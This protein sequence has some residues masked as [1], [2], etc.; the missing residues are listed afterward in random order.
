VGLVG[1]QEA[2]KAETTRYCERHAF[3]TWE[4]VRP[5]KERRNFAFCQT[6]LRC[7]EPNLCSSKFHLMDLAVDVTGPLGGH[8]WTAWTDF[9][10][11]HLVHYLSPRTIFNLSC[12]SRSL[13]LLA[14][15][16]LIP[17]CGLAFNEFT[18]PERI[19]K[20]LQKNPSMSSVSLHWANYG[21]LTKLGGLK[22]LS[23]FF[24]DVDGEG[25][26]KERAYPTQ[27]LC[28]ISHL[29][30]LEALSLWYQKDTR[31]QEG[32]LMYEFIPPEFA[33]TLKC[34]KKLKKLALTAESGEIPEALGTMTQLE[35]L[36]VVLGGHTD[37]ESRC[38]WDYF[39]HLP[40]IIDLEMYCMGPEYYK[41][42]LTLTKLTSLK[43]TEG[44]IP[45]N[46]NIFTNLETLIV[47]NEVWDEIELPETATSFKTLTKLKKLSLSSD[48]HHKTD[49]SVLLTLT[50]LA[51]TTKLFQDTFEDL[52][53]N[54][55][56]AFNHLT[57][58]TLEGPLFKKT[59]CDALGTLTNLEQLVMQFDC[60]DLLYCLSS[61]T[62]LISLKAWVVPEKPIA[63][64]SD[65]KP[66]NRP[67]LKYLSRLTNL[68]HLDI[69]FHEIPPEN[70]TCFQ[71][72]NVLTNLNSLYLLNGGESPLQWFTHLADL[73]VLGVHP[74][75]QDEVSL[76]TKYFP[77]IQKLDT[78][79]RFPSL[80]EPYKYSRWIKHPEVGA[81]PAVLVPLWKL[82][83]LQIV[84]PKTN[85]NE[86]KKCA[87]MWV[88][89]SFYE[90]EKY[91]TQ[92]VR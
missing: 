19:S 37:D 52:F 41:F 60:S 5:M 44:T 17:I 86:T 83:N 67:N 57:S 2:I 35:T 49:P 46:L 56:S 75:T 42:P 38:I 68:Q 28:S 36:I 33:E 84:L 79:Q 8:A 69:G 74:T 3:G 43:T 62:R 63:G 7:R 71:D 47:E 72:L 15:T 24:T 82:E 50:H 80:Q 32:E 70:P 23:L 20:Y 58:L 89:E 14:W 6:K 18:P 61:L 10:K 53:L 90:P 16:H 11:E 54:T 21:L 48:W 65:P 27:D 77:K 45:K 66:P 92:D 76:I 78:R 59:I 55:P 91:P 9:W 13:N 34:F 39:K 22:D 85:W 88:D 26:R 30:D 73:E 87:P 81:D 12:A 31:R 1:N 29:T 4:Q 51:M 40:N 25:P 64:Q